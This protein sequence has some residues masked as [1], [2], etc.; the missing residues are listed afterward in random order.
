[1]ILPESFE[2]LDLK[3]YFQKQT[4]KIRPDEV[5]IDEEKEKECSPEKKEE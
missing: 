2:N 3:N 1:M 4:T 5:P